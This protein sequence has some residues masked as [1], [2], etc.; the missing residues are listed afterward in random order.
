MTNQAHAA[1]VVL[2][3]KPVDDIR[4]DV[5]KQLDL[6]GGALEV[7]S[8]QQVERDHIHVHLGAPP[9]E[10]TDFCAPCT[11]PL[12]DIAEPGLAGPA[13]VAIGHYGDVLRPLLSAQ[14]TPQTVLV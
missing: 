10:L 4:D 14:L 13:A 11:V 2:G 3:G 12:R 5:E 7:L 8:G 1:R 9:N 6:F